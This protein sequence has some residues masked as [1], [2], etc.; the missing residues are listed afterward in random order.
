MKIILLEDRQGIQK[1][2]ENIYI[3]MNFK[4]FWESFQIKNL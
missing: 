1:V 4:K 2:I 3:F